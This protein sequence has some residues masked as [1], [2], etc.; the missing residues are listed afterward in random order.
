MRASVMRLPNQRHR[1]SAVPPTALRDERVKSCVL[2]RFRDGTFLTVR[3]AREGPVHSDPARGFGSRV[4][5]MSLGAILVIILILVLLGVI[6]SWGYSS[7]WGYGPSGIVG[8]ILII[9][10]I[11]VLLGRI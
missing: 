1:P 5:L 3:L 8:T 10:V 6:P 7:S 2:S 4:W 11:L 9:V